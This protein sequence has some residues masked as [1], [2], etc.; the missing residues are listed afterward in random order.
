MGDGMVRPIHRVLGGLNH[1]IP[2]TKALVGPENGPFSR[3]VHVF[4]QRVLEDMGSHKDRGIR[5]FPRVHVEFGHLMVARHSIIGHV[6]FID[7]DTGCT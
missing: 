7:G 4:P 5:L 3:K 1:R 6:D 2:F